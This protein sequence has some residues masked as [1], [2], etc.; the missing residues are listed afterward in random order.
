MS[1]KP[2][3]EV[4]TPSIYDG[5][6]LEA[7]FELRN[8]QQWIAAE[9]APY[10]RGVAAEFGAGIGAMSQW[11]LPLVDRIDVIE[12][13]PNLIGPLRQRFESTTSVRVEGKSLQAYI[14]EREPNSLD[15]AVMVN[16]LEHIEDDVGV[17]SDLK[18]LLRADGHLLIFVP[19][20]PSLYSELDRILGH[21]RRYSGKQLANVVIDAGYDII[22]LRYFDM[23]GIV[24]WW[25]VNTMGGKKRFDPGLSKLYDR[26]GVPVTR[27]IE[28]IIP[29]PR[30]KNL[31]LVA[32]KK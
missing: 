11:F 30:G 29:P 17:L 4:D 15:A 10:L 1:D 5:H 21:H 13:S 22:S 24:P 28:K 8:Y 7:L 20:M 19:A 31:I 27:T 18:L 25:L 26:I 2:N 12:P 14:A 9:F 32:R 6:D 23:L 3:Q 16:L